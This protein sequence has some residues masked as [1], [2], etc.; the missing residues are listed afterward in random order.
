MY[1]QKKHDVFLNE[2]LFMIHFNSFK[3]FVSF[4]Q[5]LNGFEELRKYIKHGSE[6]C[7]EVANILQERLVYIIYLTAFKILKKLISILL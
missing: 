4:F 3:Y 5:S 7:K 1:G 6:F 2:L